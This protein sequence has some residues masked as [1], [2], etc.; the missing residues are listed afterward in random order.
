MDLRWTTT[1]FT[2]AKMTPIWIFP[3]Y[4]LLIIGP[5]AGVLSSTLHG[6]RAF[7]I[8]VGGTT[9]Q[10]I[11]FL[12]SMLVY[13]AFIYRLMTQKLPKE[14]LRPGLFV[15]V[16]P[17]AFTVAG[18]IPMSESLSTAVPD[19]FMGNGPLAALIIRVMATWASL[20]LWGFVL[21][22]LPHFLNNSCPLT[23][24]R[25]ALW[26]FFISVF[27]HY[28]CVGTGK[29]HFAM[30]WYSFIFPNTALVTAT[31]AIARAFDNQA[32]R[33]I[34]CVMTCALICM[35]FFVFSMMIRAVVIHHILW[36]E[37]GEDRSEGGWT[38]EKSVDRRGT[39][40]TARTGMS[41][42]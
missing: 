24:H 4:P 29:M 36:P 5:H 14:S 28:S 27:A 20:W 9:L 23:L 10:G 7:E 42:V 32:I 30:T 40:S 22:Q 8:I 13:A 1:T 34:G 11:G 3:A 41:A 17:S 18:I 31:F 2:I 25:L 33:I 39:A 19:H 6:T 38:A 26:F 15:S 21:S 16:G 12:V 35:Y 37:M